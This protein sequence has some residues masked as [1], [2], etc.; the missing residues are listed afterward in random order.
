MINC[1]TRSLIPK[2]IPDYNSPVK[3][4]KWN[5]FNKKT[6]KCD[7]NHKIIKLKYI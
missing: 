7:P 4:F 1:G 3:D 6:L 5:N 2:W